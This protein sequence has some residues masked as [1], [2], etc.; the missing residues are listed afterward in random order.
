MG[1]LKS[2]HLCMNDGIACYFQSK[3]QEHFKIK[4][5]QDFMWIA[6]FGIYE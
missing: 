2:A 3:K 5:I 4:H 1:F 6:D